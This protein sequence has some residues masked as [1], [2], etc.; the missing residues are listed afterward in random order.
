MDPPLELFVLSWGVYPRRV[1]TYL[2]EKNLL[3]SPLIKVSESTANETGE[4][5]APRKP[6][7][8]V[9]VLRLPDGSFIKQSIAIIMYFED[10]CDHP[11]EPWQVELSKQANGS[12]LGE[13]AAE[14]ARVRDMLCLADEITSQFVL[15]CHK[16]TALFVPLET[17]NATASKLIMEY[18]YKNL[19]L[20]AKYY[21]NDSRFDG[22]EA[23]VNV[24]DCVLQ[25]VLYFGKDVYSLDLVVDPELASLR[26]FYEWMEKRESVKVELPCPEWIQ[27]LASRWLPVE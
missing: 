3:N 21:D 1:L 19:K 9:P 23:K 5:S 24:A 18:C 22:D 11:E 17:T 26:G 12:M 14:K 15:A 4:L 7:G 8:S 16:G 6:K 10:I 27:K 2:S 25:A 13:T 20:L